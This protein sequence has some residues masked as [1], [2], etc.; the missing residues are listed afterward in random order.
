[1]TEP[2]SVPAS[3][4]V[5]ANA[6]VP[7]AESAP[8]AP[9]PYRRPPNLLAFPNFSLAERDRRWALVREIMLKRDVPYLVV[10][11]GLRQS[12]RA[13]AIARYVSHIGGG[14]ARVGVVF[15]LEGEPTAFVSDPEDWTQTQPWCH[16]VQPLPRMGTAE[17]V[18]LLQRS[19]AQGRRV[20]IAGNMDGSARTAFRN[21]GGDVDW[22]DLTAD[23]ERI[24]AIKSAE[25]ISFLRRSARIAE[26]ALAEVENSLPLDARDSELWAT[27][28][29]RLCT[30]GSEL[31]VDIRWAMDPLSDPAAL[32]RV[33]S[34]RPINVV[35]ALLGYIDAAWGGYHAGS[36]A[37]FTCGPASPSIPDLAATLSGLWSESV[38]NIAPGR[39]LSELTDYI[40]TEVS[41]IKGRGRHAGDLSIV[42]VLHGCG[43][44]RDL[45]VLSATESGVARHATFIEAGWC[46]FWGLIARSGAGCACVGDSIVIEATGARRLGTGPIGLR[47][48][49]G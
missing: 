26:A 28:L 3:G 19:G 22:I 1:M 48:L 42:P 14:S 5:P 7:P 44:G 41:Q 11:A 40:A 6:P 36:M 2:R 12:R 32:S 30:L 4:A 20:G 38:E 33:P 13:R 17:L 34:F 25:E 39:D 45:P 15:S 10:P 24:R 29:Q 49:S 35:G 21:G 47:S 27:P 43:L 37:T 8:D 23:L 9:P 16:D 18:E 46:F 31:P